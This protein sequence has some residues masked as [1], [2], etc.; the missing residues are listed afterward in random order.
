VA[1]EDREFAVVD[2]NPA[3]SVRRVWACDRKKGVYPL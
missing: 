1:R 2:G 3:D